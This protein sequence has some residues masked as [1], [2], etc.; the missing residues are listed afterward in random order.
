MTTELDNILDDLFHGC[1]LHA[2][3]EQSAAQQA[4]PDCEA[5]RRRAFD[6]YE[7]ALRSRHKSPA[8]GQ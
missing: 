7:Q 6:Q 1:A 2:F 8:N 3:L 5:T 4:P